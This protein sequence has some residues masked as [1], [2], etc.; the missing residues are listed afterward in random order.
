MQ[1]KGNQDKK[2]RLCL[3]RLPDGLCNIGNEAGARFAESEGGVRCRRRCVI[4]YR[5]DHRCCAT[6]AGAKRRTKV[7]VLL[8]MMVHILHMTDAA[9]CSMSGQVIAARD[10]A[11]AQQQETQYDSEVSHVTNVGDFNL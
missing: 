2:G 4:R 7:V 5:R 6:G 11:N 8:I 1:A 9:L 10:R 3:G